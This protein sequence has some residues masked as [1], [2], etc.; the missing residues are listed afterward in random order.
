MVVVKMVNWKL[1]IRN[2]DFIQKIS[3]MS[4][5]GG[6]LFGTTGGSFFKAPGWVDMKKSPGTTP[7]VLLL[8][9]CILRIRP[10]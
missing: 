2:F 4:G 9:E 1:T 10:S 7:Q 3:W 5:A 8:L 6:G